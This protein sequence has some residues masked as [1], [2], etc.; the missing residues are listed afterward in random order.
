MEALSGPKR[1]VRLAVIAANFFGRFLL[2]PL[3]ELFIGKSIVNSMELKRACFAA[4]QQ[5]VWHLH[6]NLNQEQDKL[7]LLA[8]ALVIETQTRHIADLNAPWSILW[9][10]TGWCRLCSSC[11]WCTRSG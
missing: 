6:N 2:P 8:V 7:D 10:T 1:S 4:L 11:Q 9:G 3:E 5:D